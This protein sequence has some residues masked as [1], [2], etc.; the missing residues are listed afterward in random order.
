MKYFE[1][2]VVNEELRKQK[3]CIFTIH[4]LRQNHKKCFKY[5][6]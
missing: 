5:T 2:I 6:N 4:F 3:I 1:K